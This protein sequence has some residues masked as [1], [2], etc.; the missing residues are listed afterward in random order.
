MLNLNKLNSYNLMNK[1]INNNNFINAFSPNTN[2][3]MPNNNFYRP[4]NVLV[5][6]G[7]ENLNLNNNINNTN[8]NN[9]DIA[10]IEG[11]L[12]LSDRIDEV[13]YKKIRGKFIK[14]ITNQNGSRIFQ[15]YLK[16]TNYYIITQIYEEV[17]NFLNELMTDSYGNYFCQKFFGCLNDEDRTNFMKKVIIK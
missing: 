1:P 12:A 8:I 2:N 7:N 13:L 9:N 11:Y 16:N 10:E 3:N 6:K 15:K 17:F 4:P 14:I 5:R